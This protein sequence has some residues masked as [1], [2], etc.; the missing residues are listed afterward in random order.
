MFTAAYTA[1]KAAVIA[2]TR[3]NAIDYAKLGIRVNCICPGLV[4]TSMTRGDADYEKVVA[5]QVASTPIQRRG[6]VS[7]IVDSILFMSST[8]AS[9]MLG[10]AMVVDGGYVIV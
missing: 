4:D 9:Y 2:L 1:S 3:A 8:K 5:A 10:H 6:K 7:E